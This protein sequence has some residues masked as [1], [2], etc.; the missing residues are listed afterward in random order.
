MVGAPAPQGG[1][2]LGNRVQPELSAFLTHLCDLSGEA[3]QAS[4]SASATAVLRFRLG[5]GARLSDPGLT[6]SRRELR[7]RGRGQATALH[8]VV[9]CRALSFCRD[10]LVPV[11]FALSWPVSLLTGGT[12]S[13]PRVLLGLMDCPASSWLPPQ[14]SVVV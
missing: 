12:A 14:T 8:G 4:R 10:P 7:Q 1:L 9:F 13:G 5:R 11:S 2:G 3:D 6:T